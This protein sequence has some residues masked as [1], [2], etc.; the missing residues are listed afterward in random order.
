MTS[1]SNCRHLNKPQT[2]EARRSIRQ[3]YHGLPVKLQHC[4][5]TP[6]TRKRPSEGGGKSGSLFNVQSELRAHLARIEE[7]FARVCFPETGQSRTA[8]P[9]FDSPIRLGEKARHVSNEALRRLYTGRNQQGRDGV[10]PQTYTLTALFNGGH[11]TGSADS[12]LRA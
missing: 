7:A 1:G 4:R 10:Y 6:V 8:K 3:A 11:G 9:I 2:E 5:Y 12:T